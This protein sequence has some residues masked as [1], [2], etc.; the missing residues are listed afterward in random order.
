MFVFSVVLV[1]PAHPCCL[2]AANECSPLELLTTHASAEPQEIKDNH[3]VQRAVTVQ[4]NSCW[5]KCGL[6]GGK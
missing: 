3:K 5:E 4:E 2:K 6:M 1:G